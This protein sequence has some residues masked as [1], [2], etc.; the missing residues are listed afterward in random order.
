MTKIPRDFEKN[1]QWKYEKSKLRKN[2][3]LQQ[4]LKDDRKDNSPEL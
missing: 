2:F 1:K 3:F 4:K